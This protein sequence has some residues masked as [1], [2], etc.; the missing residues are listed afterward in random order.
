[1]INL[2]IIDDNLYYSKTLIN[3]IA[4]N[5][6]NFKLYKILTNGKE[7]LDTIINEKDFIDI[8]L[9]DLKMP[10]LNGL[11][12]LKEIHYKELYSYKNSIIVISGEA[13][14]IAKLRNNPYIYS[15]IYKTQGFSRILDS[16]NELAKLK[17]ENKENLEEKI[18]NEL[19]LLKFSDKLVGTKYLYEAI[20]LISQNPNLYMKDLKNYIY[21]IIA[22]KYNVSVHNI[23]CNINN[24]TIIMNCDCEKRIIMN[25]FGFFDEKAE[26]KPKQVIEAIFKKVLYDNDYIEH[27]KS[28]IF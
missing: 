14:M 23:K 1:M 13:E 15:F 3:M 24:A 9:L 20:L 8:I 5:N 10:I 4:E 19:K 22:K 16:I 11:E 21:P 25:Y 28:E 26:V 17:E 27:T 18:K 12:L 7:A 2:L 6:S